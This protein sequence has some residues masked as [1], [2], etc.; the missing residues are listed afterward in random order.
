MHGFAP[1]KTL[2]GTLAW[3]RSRETCRRNVRL[4]LALVEHVQLRAVT[5]HTVPQRTRRR[6]SV[7]RVVTRGFHGCDRGQGGATV[8]AMHWW[9]FIQSELYAAVR[10]A[11][12]ARSGARRDEAESAHPIGW[13]PEEPSAV[14]VSLLQ[15]IYGFV[16]TSTSCS[17][18]GA[19]LGRR[20]RVDACPTLL[21]S[22]VWRVSV[23]T[24]CRGWRRHRHTAAVGQL[25]NDLVL[26]PVRGRRW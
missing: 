12:G 2:V 25:S 11:P 20:L 8:R 4:H 9:P 21:Q 1:V 19:P 24:R 3:S 15:I 14:D 10:G 5:P 18:C 7:P 6:L 16:A 22:V 17:R 13:G 23:R 26:G